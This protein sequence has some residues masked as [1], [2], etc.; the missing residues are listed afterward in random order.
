MN[1]REYLAASAGVVVPG[2][3]GE[4]APIPDG[5]RNVDERDTRWVKYAPASVG[6]LKIDPCTYVEMDAVSSDLES[7]IE[8]H[9]SDR[10]AV[11]LQFKTTGEVEG[12]ELQASSITQLTADQAEALADALLEAA[13][14]ARFEADQYEGGE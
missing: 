1:R 7:R 12:Q 10:N 2:A 8:I 14:G 9:P 6:T 13:E 5:G 3:A 4:L 11:N